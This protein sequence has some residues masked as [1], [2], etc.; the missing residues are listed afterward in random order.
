[1]KV[2]GIILCLL[3]SQSSGMEPREMSDFMQSAQDVGVAKFV[4]SLNED[5]KKDLALAYQY[6]NQRAMETEKEL[7]R[8]ER[9]HSERNQD[10]LKE[11]LHHLNKKTSF[12]EWVFLI[13]GEKKSLPK[14]YYEREFKRELLEIQTDF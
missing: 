4:Q 11:R 2:I 12:I 7:L 13:D 1:M 3:L 8:A 10:L 14:H 6:Y 5:K 9:S